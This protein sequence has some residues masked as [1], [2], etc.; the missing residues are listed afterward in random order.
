MCGSC[1]SNCVS[2][3]LSCDTAYYGKNTASAFVEVT[4][5]ISGQTQ[6]YTEEGSRKFL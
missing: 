4:A 2:F 1:G 6:N 3:F 5:S